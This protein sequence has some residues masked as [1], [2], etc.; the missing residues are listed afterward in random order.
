MFKESDIAA[1]FPGQASQEKGM[2]QNHSEEAK[3]IFYIASTVAEHD[4]AQF[5]RETETEEMKGPLVQ[6]ALGAVILSEL[7]VKKDKGL[8]PLLYMG[9]SVSEIIALAAALVPSF[10]KF[11]KSCNVMSKSKVIAFIIRWEIPSPYSFFSL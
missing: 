7:A 3:R 11:I 8:E 6:P 4:L 5:C 10:L 9:H 1:V 2:G